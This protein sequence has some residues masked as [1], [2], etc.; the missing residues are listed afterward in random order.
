MVGPPLARYGRVRKT[1]PVLLLQQTE[2][3]GRV[4]DR[5]TGRRPQG[6][7]DPQGH[8][9]SDD[10]ATL[11]GLVRGSRTTDEG[12]DDVSFLPIDPQPGP[13]VVHATEGRP[14]R[15]DARPTP[16]RRLAS[17]RLKGLDDQFPP[18]D[19]RRHVQLGDPDEQL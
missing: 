13:D 15:T 12:D 8:P 6:R 3:G 5:R 19:L 14:G 4:L 17:G 18:S 10:G 11:C 2:T 7:F 1:D 16:P 9:D